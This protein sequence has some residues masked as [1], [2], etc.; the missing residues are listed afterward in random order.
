MCIT[1]PKYY[2]APWSNVSMALWPGQT[3]AADIFLSA[4]PSVGSSISALCT[5][6]SLAGAR[7][8][9]FPPE[10]ASLSRNPKPLRLQPCSSRPL[11]FFLLWLH[12]ISHIQQTRFLF[13]VSVWRPIIVF[14]QSRSQKGI[15][16]W[17]QISGEG[18]LPAVV[19]GFKFQFFTAKSSM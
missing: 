10:V 5:I 9:R 11:F 13:L 2:F 18:E 6:T 7:L 12:E 1:A 3:E 4:R 19:I 8:S 14:S 16:M 15:W 17:S